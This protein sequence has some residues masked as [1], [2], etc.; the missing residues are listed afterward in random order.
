[1]RSKYTADEFMK[2]SCRACRATSTRASRSIRSCVAA[3]RLMEERGDSARADLRDA[4]EFW[5]TVNLSSKPQWGFQLEPFPRPGGRATRVIYTEYDLPRDTIEPHDVDRRSGR[6]RLV[7]ELRRAESSAGSI[8][9]PARSPNIRS[10]EHKPG[11]PTGSLAL[12]TDQDGNLWLGN[13]Y[14]ATIVKFDPQDREIH[15]LAAAE[16]AEHRRRPGQHGEPA[17]LARR[18]QGLV[19]EQRLCRRPPARPRHRQD[20]D[21]GAVQGR[22][23]AAQ[24]L[25]RDPG[26]Q[27]QRVLHRLPAAAHRPHRR[28]DRRGQ[29]VRSADGR[30]RR[31][32]AAR[33]MRRTGCGSRST[34]ATASRCSTPRPRSSRSGGCTPRWS[35]PYDVTSTR[36]RKPGPARC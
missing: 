28:Q 23:G 29:D 3:E 31:P 25:R 15:V 2:I 33:W 11:F 14:Q 22:Q 19:A 36:T 16:G 27:E 32:A 9:R 12:R 21:L 18:R 20:R 30:R 35:A 4:A 6:H 26:L 7:L 1:M 34:A 5:A 10:P 24:H 17:K 8:P 13:M